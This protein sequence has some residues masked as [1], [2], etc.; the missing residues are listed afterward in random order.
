VSPTAILLALAVLV[1]FTVEAAIG[2][3]AT[4]VAL[5]IGSL[6][7]PTADVLVRVV[8][9]NL[10]LSLVITVQARQAVDLRALFSR[11]L[12]AM[13]LGFP[14]GIISVRHLADSQMQRVLAVFLLALAVLELVQMARSPPRVDRRLSRWAAGTLLFVGGFAHGALATGGPPV[15]Y[16]AARSLPDKTVFRATLSAL[17]LLLNLVLVIVYALGARVT[18]ATLYESAPLLPVVACGIALGDAIHRR[19]PERKFTTIVFS[20]LFVIALLLLVRA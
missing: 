7:M 10:V 16:V 13:A 14:L 2:F 17:W 8:P 12:P 18:P 5:A 9:L 15:V 6:V 1:G 3:G 19:V 4:L 11:V 20:L